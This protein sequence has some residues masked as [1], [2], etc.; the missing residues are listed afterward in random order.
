MLIIN[1]KINQRNKMHTKR[2]ATSKTWPIPRKGTKYV[3]TP[4]H[5]R[6]NGIPILVVL[7]DVLKIVAN[8]KEFKKMAHE[9]E[10][11]VNNKPVIK[12]NLAIG[13]FDVISFKTSGVN[14]QII[15]TEKG[16]LG[17]K[18]IDKAD[19]KIVSVVDKKML[20]GK[21]LQLNLSD[22]RNILSEDKIA[23]GDS[24]VINFKDKKI[25]KVIPMKEG[26]TVLFIKGKHAGHQGKVKKV[27]GKIATVD[28]KEAEFNVKINELVVVE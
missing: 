7:R 4:S 24:V 8:K 27:E 22:G 26:A 2:H 11:L 12:P 5:N 1:L 9:K 16:K 21:K 23:V 18:E 28:I 20:K 17:V 3:I 14:H 25:G 19:S 10:I 15:L 6:K 13:L